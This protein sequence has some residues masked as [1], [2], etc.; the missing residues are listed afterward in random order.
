MMNILLRL[1]TQTITFNRP[2]FILARIAHGRLWLTPKRKLPA[3]CVASP[4]FTK[5]SPPFRR[6]MMRMKPTR[7]R[8]AM[9]LLPLIFERKMAAP[10]TARQMR[11]LR[12]GICVFLLVSDDRCARMK[13]LP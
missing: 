6:A 2:S 12:V 10:T 3:L 11:Q 13:A 8:N 5:A 9:F 4:I 1:I 7:I